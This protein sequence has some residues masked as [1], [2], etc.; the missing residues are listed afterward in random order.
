[1]KGHWLKTLSVQWV[2]DVAEKI[3]TIDANTDVELAESYPPRLSKMSKK[4]IAIGLEIP[5]GE[6]ESEKLFSRRSLLDADI[7][8]F[9]PSIPQGY[10]N[11]TY[12]GKKCLSDD[13]S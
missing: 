5:G 12:Q 1:M 7:V 4:L 8:I 9:R 13:G 3:E 2:N 11:D 10:E 6:I